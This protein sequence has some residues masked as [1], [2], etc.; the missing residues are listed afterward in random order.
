MKGEGFTVFFKKTLSILLALTMVFS[1]FT[2]IE[3]NTFAAEI[4]DNMTLREKITQMMM[5]DFRYWDE[6]TSDSNPQKGLTVMNDQVRQIVEDYNFGAI[7]NFSQNLIDT[8]QTLNLMKEYQAAATKNGGIP[9]LIAADQEGGTVYRLS[10]GTALPGNMALGATYASNGTEYAGKAGEIIGSELNALGINTNLAPVVDVNN[11]PNNPVIGLRSYSDNAVIV[12]ELAAAEIEGMNRYN[13]IGCAKHF[14][15]HGDTATDSHYGLPMV[16]KTLSVL[17]ENELKPYEAVINKGV[18]MV[19]T[20]HI[21]YP[22]LEDDKIVSDKTGEAES[23]P[24][25]MSDDILT[26]LLKE[27]MGFEGI[28]ITDAMNMAGIT[29]KWDPVQACVIAVQAGV[30]MVCMPTALCCQED[31]ANLNAIIDGIGKAVNDGDIPMSRINDAVIRILKVKKNRGILDYNAADYTAE[32]AKSVVGCETNRNMEREI[33]AAA[34]TVVK[35]ENNVLPLKVT[36]NSKILMLVPYN[37]ERAQMIM[38]WNRAK[39]AGLIP[40]GAQV[41]YFR[42]T[43]STAFSEELMT[44][45]DWADTYIINSEISSVA[46]MANKH[47]LSEFPDKICNYAA[48]NGKTAVVVSVDKPY[49]VQLYPNADAIVAAYGYKGSSVDPTEALIGG[50]IGSRTAYGPNIIAA[51][52]VILGTYGAQG[53]LPLDIPVYDEESNSYTDAL[54]Y[55]RGYGLTYDSLL[56][57]PT[58]T[59]TVINGKAS[60]LSAV[61]GEVITVTAEQ[62]D[63]KV[64]SH[65]EVDGAT[66]SDDNAK[67]TTLIMEDTDATAEAIYDNCDCKCHKRGFAGSLYRILLFLQKLFGC[68]LECFCGKKH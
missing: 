20:A 35:N 28:V 30:D 27:E 10:T 1:L 68:N 15:G 26:V 24:A 59:L 38:G 56:T 49:D 51:V 29:D 3:V 5:V 6:D 22:Q 54:A 63:G 62:I 67:E 18:D 65:W 61:S 44:K 40:E 36:G 47:W 52:E 42:F 16:D 57:P 9:M 60:A 58:Y 14:P 43:D 25:T 7:I 21:L 31:L 19:M 39:A 37:N 34:V 17:K 45:L 41:D 11:N 46:R 66:V 64:F 53:K 48:D 4:I 13:V 8:E 2:V 55:N 12:G 33:S 32:K 23:L 50:S